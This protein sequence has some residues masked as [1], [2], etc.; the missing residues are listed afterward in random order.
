MSQLLYIVATGNDEGVIECDFGRDIYVEPGSYIAMKQFSGILADSTIP[1]EGVAMTYTTSDTPSAPEAPTSHIVTFRPGVNIPVEV[2]NNIFLNYTTYLMNAALRYYTTPP[3]TLRKL[4]EKNDIGFEWDVRAVNGAVTIKWAHI[5]PSTPAEFSTFNTTGTEVADAYTY[6][7]TDKAKPGMAVG[8]E[9]IS[10]GAGMHTFQITTLVNDGGQFAVGLVPAG[11]APSVVDTDP[12]ATMEDIVQQF[13]FCVTVLETSLRYVGYV[14]G[15]PDVTELA[16]ADVG[17]QI[18]FIRDN[19]SFFVL[20]FDA[21]G[22]IKEALFKTRYTIPQNTDGSEALSCMAVAFTSGETTISANL[23]QK[24]SFYAADVENH[25]TYQTDTPEKAI[26]GGDPRR[27]SSYTTL[28]AEDPPET[29]DMKEVAPSVVSIFFAKDTHLLY[30]FTHPNL[31]KGPLVEGSFTADVPFAQFAGAGTA[32]L[33][34]DSLDIESYD[35]RTR[36][37][38]NVLAT[39]PLH[40]DDPNSQRRIVYEPSYPV[41]FDVNAISGPINMRNVRMRLLSHQTL[42]PI[43]LSNESPVSIALIVNRE[44]YG[45][46]PRKKAIM[47]SFVPTQR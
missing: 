27:I 18:C 42:L 29:V 8:T 31:V 39:I 4:P 24:S 13:Y 28:D 3:P 36:G 46:P 20:I 23:V 12:A 47:S 14:N 21:A 41:F 10:R 38:S 9:V 35:S 11:M 44:R 5:D 26:S 34:I 25:V 32:A 2:P 40:L 33:L 16:T 37:R 19:G 45:E 43:R 1:S 7:L 22:G 6:A 17:D 15:V 30:G